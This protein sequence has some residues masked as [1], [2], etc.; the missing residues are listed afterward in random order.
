MW[1]SL[2]AIRVIRE[3]EQNVP[4]KRADDDYL[5]LIQRAGGKKKGQ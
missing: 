1:F 3:T 2:R 4:N 5:M